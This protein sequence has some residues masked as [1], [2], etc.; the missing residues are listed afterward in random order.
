MTEIEM[1][2]TR[3]DLLPQGLSRKTRHRPVRSGCDEGQ[4]MLLGTA[5]REMEA[6]TTTLR[7]STNPV[8]R[9]P[10]ISLFGSRNRTRG[11]EG[12]PREPRRLPGRRRSQ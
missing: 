12:I 9:I 6:D 11:W 8:A 10:A 2:K 4:S 7:E 1:P 5:G 3:I